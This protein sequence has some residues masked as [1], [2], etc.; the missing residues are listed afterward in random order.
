M[1]VIDQFNKYLLENH[2]ILWNLRIPH[3]TIVLVPSLI[4]F[5]FFGFIFCDP[6]EYRWSI[7]SS[8]S[9]IFYFLFSISILG[10]I[11]MFILW[12]VKYN[13]NNSV[14]NFYPR[15]QISVYLEW[16]GIVFITF[17]FVC[18][19]F[20]MICGASAKYAIERSKSSNP[21]NRETVLMGSILLPYDNSQYMLED[22]EKALKLAENSNIN[23]IPAE[24]IQQTSNGLIYTGPSFLYYNRGYNGYFS[25]DEVEEATLNMKT[26]LKNED[27]N[28]VKKVMREYLDYC[29]KNN[30]ETDL[31]VNAW[32]NM[33]YN[34][35][36][37]PVNN[38]NMIAESRYSS[39][40]S[41]DD[42]EEYYDRPYVDKSSAEYYLND[43]Y[44]SGTTETLP[45]LQYM[46][47]ISICLS[48]YV[49]SYRFSKG[50]NI[51]FAFISIVVIWF[52]FSIISIFFATMGIDAPGFYFLFWFIP[53]ILAWGLLLHKTYNNLP[54]K[55]SRIYF[56][57]GVWS[58]PIL[59]PYLTVF[60]FR[61]DI[62]D[63]PIL[64]I[65]NLLLIFGM[66]LPVSIFS[67][68][69]KA[70]PEE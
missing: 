68:K 1:K 27:A 34:P 11:V 46:L 5:F 4:L 20:S 54:K 66:M 6:T 26:F 57:I 29:K 70:L 28:N 67:V 69:W 63:M 31:S 44:Y 25:S 15:S 59:F 62:F 45:W 21:Q 13:N 51:L 14:E 2:P 61:E 38:E 60:F 56:H 16:L 23:N 35:P 58:V 3:L 41:S 18:I 33:V 32:F 9:T 7:F 30:I 65:L 19:P 12:L 36:Y 39:Y 10:S 55:H 8:L 64:T 50:V 53:I 48:L 17:L 40:S 43:Y 52:A 47:Y 37:Y 22:D 42:D 49:F 24:D